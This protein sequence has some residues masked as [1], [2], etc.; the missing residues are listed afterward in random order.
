LGEAG[1]REGDVDQAVLGRHEVEGIFKEE[2]VKD[3]Y[4]TDLGLS[5]LDG[6]G[7]V[8]KGVYRNDIVE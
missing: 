5:V 7:V 1:D 8:W 4:F 6:V 3:G 2:E